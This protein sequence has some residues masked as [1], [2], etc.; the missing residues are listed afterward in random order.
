MEIPRLRSGSGVGAMCYGSY[1]PKYMMRDVEARVTAGAAR[2]VVAGAEVPSRDGLWGL[3][4][5]VAA[6]LAGRKDVLAGERVR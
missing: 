4:T 3:V 5:R 2:G 1:D 6:S